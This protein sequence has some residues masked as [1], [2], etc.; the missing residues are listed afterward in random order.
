MEGDRTQTQKDALGAEALWMRREPSISFSD[1]TGNAH[2]QVIKEKVIVGTAPSSDVVLVDR[3]VSR[4]HAE[5]DPRDD[6]L[7]VRDLSSRNGTFLEGIRVLAARAP[8]GCKVQLGRTE[9]TVRYAAE[10]TP[11]EL[12]QNT[13]F[14][15][16]VGASVPMRA[17]FARLARIAPSQATVLIDGETGTGKELAARAIHDA[18][19][20]AQGP[21]VVI[22]CGALPENLLEAE[23]FGHAKGAFTGAQ[24]ARAGAIEEAEGGTVFLDE[25]GELPLSMQ[26][27]LLRVLESR[28]VRRLGE[29]QHRAVDVRFISATHRDLRTMANNRAFREDLY[30]R[31]AVLPITVP[32]LR[33][34]PGDLPI[35]IEHLLPKEARGTISPDLLRELAGRPWLGNVRE[36]RNFLER[37]A[38]LGAP[39]ALELA[40]CHGGSS[41]D[42]WHPK[43]SRAMLELPLREL[44][45]RVVDTVEREYFAHLLERCDRNVAKGAELA[46]LNRTY[47]YRLMAKYRL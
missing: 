33:E 7:W 29:T 21:F 17:L 37:A 4:L 41:Q 9:L 28:M 3:A 43:L 12:S 42:G 31:L 36:L 24:A 11:V 13:A 26:P 27:K 30:F 16:L 15:G 35:L 47:V 40:G 39:E 45:E 6:G 23:L 32:P 44:R 46:G 5:L 20:R 25:I 22:D 19:P 14:G 18:S 10:P 34:R 1:E 8:N 2:H 38:T